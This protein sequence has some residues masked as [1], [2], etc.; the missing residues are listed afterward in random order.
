MGLAYES[1]KSGALMPVLA[2]ANHQD[3]HAIV[4]ALN[5]GLDIFISWDVRYK[6]IRYDLTKKPELIEEYILRAG[7]HGILVRFGG[8]YRSYPE[9]VSDVCVGV[10]IKILK[11]TPHVV[12]LE[13][14]LLRTLLEKA[15]KGMSPEDREALEEN[16][17]AQAGPNIL[18]TDILAGGAKFAAFL[19][20]IFTSIADTAI[21]RGVIGAG[22]VIASRAGLS[23]LGPIGL[24][25]GTVWIT[26]DLAGPSLNATIPAVT[27]VALLRQR[28]IW[29]E[30]Q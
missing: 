16:I 7:S 13:S 3:L 29:S 2:R 30:T 25:L 23:W 9:I 19:P 21:V 28:L 5:R 10:G 15:L 14:L 1:L 4:E 27:L 6:E 18:V 12:E 26:Y 22:G 24:I 11:P 20:L 8:S 17:K